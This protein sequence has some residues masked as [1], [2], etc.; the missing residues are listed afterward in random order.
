VERTPFTIT[1]TTPAGSLDEVRFMS[2]AFI[3]G[4]CPGTYYLE[5]YRTD[6]PEDHAVAMFS[7]SNPPN[8]TQPQSGTITA[9][10]WAVGATTDQG[11][12]DIVHLDA[13]GPDDTGPA[14]VRIAGRFMVNAPGWNVDFSVDALAPA[15]VCLIE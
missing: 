14:M 10:A 6:A 2:L 3:G 13:P 15:Y 5:L 1:G 12:F 7:V 11:S 4:H 9:S 8:A